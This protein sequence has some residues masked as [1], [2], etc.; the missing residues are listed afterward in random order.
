MTAMSQNFAPL[1]L[2]G[3]TL[4]ILLNLQLQTQKTAWA[5]LLLAPVIHQILNL[6]PST[7]LHPR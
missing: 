2:G 7:A 5:I 3:G 4:Q 1:E 6:W